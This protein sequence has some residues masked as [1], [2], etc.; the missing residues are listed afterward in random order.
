M[1]PIISENGAFEGKVLDEPFRVT[2]AAELEEIERRIRFNGMYPLRCTR[3][4][5]GALV[6]DADLREEAMRTEMVKSVERWVQIA[7]EKL[8]DSTAV[9]VS[10]PGNDDDPAIDAPLNESTRIKNCDARLLSFEQVADP[11]VG[12][13][14]ATPWHSPREFPEE[15][16]SLRL[17]EGRLRLRSRPASYREHTRSSVSIDVG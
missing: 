13:S 8:D 1:V 6:E 3:E 14:N 17:R 15:E 2:T 11:G 16:L 5:F 9:C 7:E 10:L 12:A 4:E